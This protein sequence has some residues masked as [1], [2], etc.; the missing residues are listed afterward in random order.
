[1]CYVFPQRERFH[2][3]LHLVVG[4]P[5]LFLAWHY[6]GLTLQCSCCRADSLVPQFSNCFNFERPATLWHTISNYMASH[7]VLKWCVAEAN[8]SYNNKHRC[9]IVKESSCYNPERQWTSLIVT[10]FLQ[11]HMM[12]HEKKSSHVWYHIFKHKIWHISEH[13]GCLG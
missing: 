4:M 10:W 8:F 13:K 9:C 6:R 7:L 2:L 5:S 11:R 1:M 3:P 12:A